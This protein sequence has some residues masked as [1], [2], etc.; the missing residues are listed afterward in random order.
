M[1]D[2]DTGIGSSVASRIPVH[3]TTTAA[4]FPASNQSD[5]VSTPDTGIGSTPT[6]RN[7]VWDEAARNVTVNSTQTTFTTSNGGPS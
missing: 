3:F 5:T 4:T 1:T 7:D 6:G 2:L